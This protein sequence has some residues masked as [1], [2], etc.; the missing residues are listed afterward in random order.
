MRLRARHAIFLGIGFLGALLDLLSKT[1]IFHLLDCGGSGRH[2][3]T[4]VP[5][6]VELECV[7]NPGGIWGIGREYSW[8]LMVLRVVA[9]AVI[10]ILA[11]RLDGQARWFRWG[12]CLVFAGAIGNLV[13][14][15]LHDGR[16]RDF[17]KVW[18]RW[19][20]HAYPWPT[21]NLA[22]SLICCGAGLL[23]LDVFLRRGEIPAKPGRDD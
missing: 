16:V 5:R 2:N 4:L 1:W 9:V 10:L 8:V 3:L 12:L 6:Y 22:D 18:L 7:L 21:F 17:L 23:V 11:L 14:S 20:E 15:F 19:G 13:D